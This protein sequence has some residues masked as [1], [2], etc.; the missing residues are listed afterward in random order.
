MKKF[1]CVIN[2]VSPL[3][4]KLSEIYEYGILYDDYISSYQ[5]QILY[6]PSINVSYFDKDIGKIDTD[7]L[8]KS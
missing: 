4:G 7:I 8:K 6:S 3:G 1:P 2:S 5:E